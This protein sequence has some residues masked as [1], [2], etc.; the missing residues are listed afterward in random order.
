MD[1]AR[2]YAQAGTLQVSS[3]LKAIALFH[4]ARALQAAGVKPDSVQAYRSLLTLYGDQYD[5]TETP[6][7]LS[8]ATAPKALAQQIFAS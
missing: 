3:R 4:K 8:L 7:A 2:I 5:E 6:Y 1:A